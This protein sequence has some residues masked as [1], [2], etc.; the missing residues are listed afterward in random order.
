[1]KP[2]PWCAAI[3]SATDDVIGTVL[4]GATLPLRAKGASHC[5][6]H[7][8]RLASD[9]GIHVF[10]RAVVVF[11]DPPPSLFDAAP[12]VYRQVQG[13]LARHFGVNATIDAVSR[14]EARGLLR[15][16][17]V[18][19]TAPVELPQAPMLYSAPTKRAA[20]PVEPTTSPEPPPP[21]P[22]DRQGSLF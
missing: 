4:H 7:R 14:D 17:W 20:R 1:M 2:F 15:D 5:L 8:E 18:A 12:S 9:G 13:D 10:L 21:P 11:D 22:S 16:G 19:L 3:A 6:H